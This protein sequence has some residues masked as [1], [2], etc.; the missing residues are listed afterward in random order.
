MA[1]EVF[2]FFFFFF[3][4]K[5]AASKSKFEV[6]LRRHTFGYCA[7]YRAQKTAEASGVALG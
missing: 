4:N 7:F 3:K 2:F 1:G 5:C 6:R